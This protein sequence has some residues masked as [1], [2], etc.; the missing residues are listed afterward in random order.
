[1]DWSEKLQ[2]NG[3]PDPGRE[4]HKHERFK[5]RLLTWIEQR[6]LG[7]RQLGGFRNYELAGDYE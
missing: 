2:M 6:L 7:G 5:Y 3:T 1:M 4:P